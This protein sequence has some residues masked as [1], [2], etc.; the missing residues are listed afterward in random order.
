MKTQQQ[1]SNVNTAFLAKTGIDLNQV[2][3]GSE[4]WLKVRLGVLTASNASKI[5]AKTDSDIRLTYMSEL[6]AQIATGEAEEIK[7]AALQWGK[8]QENAARSS[9]SFESGIEI[10]ELPFVFKDESFR[11]GCSPDGTIS[12]LRGVEIKCPFNAA[13]HVKFVCADKIKPEYQWQI[14]YSMWVLDCDQYDFCSFHPNMKRQQIKIV[15]VDKDE[16]MQKTISDAA[17]QFINDM[18]LMLN[19]IG[20]EYG[21]QWKT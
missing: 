16:K 11:V 14:Q 21:Q 10:K 6:V 15:T 12:D 3:Q 20:L 5:V 13:N 8:D 7:G 1:I 9:Y 19:K 2:Q 18:N 17:P 4:M